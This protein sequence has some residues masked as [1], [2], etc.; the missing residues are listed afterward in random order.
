[1]N[2]C[3]LNVSIPCWIFWLP[4]I[5]ILRSIIWRSAELALAADDAEQQTNPRR[6]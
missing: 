5:T 6:P 2:T 1:M 3:S 4:V